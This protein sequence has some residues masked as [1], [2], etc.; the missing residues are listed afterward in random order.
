MLF[1]SPNYRTFVRSRINYILAI[2][3]IIL[4]ILTL[5]ANIYIIKKGFSPLEGGFNFSIMLMISNTFIIP[6]VATFFKN[7][8]YKFII[9]LLNILGMFIAVLG[10]FLAFMMITIQC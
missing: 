10:I 4:N 6:A 2:S 8:S 3:I 9:L 7:L 5:S 1:C